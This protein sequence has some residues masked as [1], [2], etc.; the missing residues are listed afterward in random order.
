MLVRIIQKLGLGKIIYCGHSLGSIYASYFIEKYP[1]YV[2]GYIN[3]TG[4]VN[5]WYTGL[6]AFFYRS[7][8]QWE[9]NNIES[10]RQVFL[11]SE[12]E[13]KIQ[14][15]KFLNATKDYWFGPAPFP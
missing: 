12:E 10:R 6:L 4:I 13:R 2:E 3:V 7:I 11:M 15:F 1:E 14:H 5:T 8:A 9:F